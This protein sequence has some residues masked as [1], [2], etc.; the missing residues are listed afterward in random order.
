MLLID[1][2]RWEMAAGYR[3]TLFVSLSFGIFTN[4]VTF[5]RRCHRVMKIVRVGRDGAATRAEDIKREY[6]SLWEGTRAVSS[7]SCHSTGK[8]QDDTMHSFFVRVHS[9]RLASYEKMKK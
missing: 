8:K 9:Q 2:A 4:D 7:S 6:L 5:S 1:C 3:A